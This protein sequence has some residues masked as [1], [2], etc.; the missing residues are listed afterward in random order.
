M[1]IA[2]P[3]SN[4]A[5]FQQELIGTWT[6]QDF[7]T[8]NGKPVGGQKNPLSYNIMPLP[9]AVDPD[10]FIL[11][12]FT[13]YEM[14][15][16][17]D[18]IAV[19][20]EAPNRGG[21]VSQNCR[22]L[23]Y[24]QQV[25]FAEGPAANSI[26]HVENG[27]WLWLPRF[28]QQPGPFPA[29]ID[30]ESVTN[31]LNQPASVAIA[32]QIS[33][34]HGNSILALGG[35]DTVSS[36]D[37]A[38]IC[39]ADPAIT[40]RPI[41]PDA[42]FPYPSPAVAMENPAAPPPPTLISR[43]NID[44]RYSTLQNSM[45]NFQNPHPEFTQCPNKPLQ[46]AV[47]IIQPDKFMHWQVTTEPTQHGEDL[48]PGDG[49]GVVTN[50]PFEHRVSRVTEYFADYWMLFKKDGGKTKKYLAYTQTILMQMTI[51]GEKYSFPHVTCNTLTAT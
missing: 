44:N 29:D 25:L 3:K 32:K 35:F 21:L 34:P 42:P 6:N 26:V 37:G 8:K 16:F 30:L 43:L 15:N 48:K 1:P 41:I 4:L 47:A 9:E 28:V 2:A 51:K 50:I 10:G 18:S 46:E 39:K 22:A 17:N 12:N 23:F 38:G 5:L 24:E 40:G 45:V 33:I 7:G 11:K 13:F 27:C 36:T 49:T 31:S 20:A 19:M 14:L